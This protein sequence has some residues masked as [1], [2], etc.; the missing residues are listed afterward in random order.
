MLRSVLYSIIH[1]DRSL[2][3]TTAKKLWTDGFNSCAAN[4]DSLS[5]NCCTSYNEWIHRHPVQAQSKLLKTL[6]TIR[7]I[8]MI[9]LLFL[10]MVSDFKGTIRACEA[11]PKGP[12][13]SAASSEGQHPYIC[14]ACDALTHG[15]TL[16]INR[17]IHRALNLKYPRS[18]AMRATKP[19]VNHNFV[20]SKSLEVALH[21]KGA[22]SCF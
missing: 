16:P 22:V 12:C 21:T 9:V 5:C 10:K 17:L 11:A 8:R 15:K 13:M 20:S 6:Y 14:D 2:C 3:A 19:G 18:D 7:F 1:Q 4:S